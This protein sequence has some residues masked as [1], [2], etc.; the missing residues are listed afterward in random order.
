MGKS[1][2]PTAWV[3]VDWV[4]GRKMPVVYY[5]PIFLIEECIVRWWPLKDSGLRVTKV[6]FSDHGEPE[7]TEGEAYSDGSFAMRNKFKRRGVWKYTIT[8]EKN[9]K[10][11]C[12]DPEACN[13]DQV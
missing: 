13:E 7:F 11:F 9:G 12:L 2:L 10:E 6:A 5:D 3:P 8:V 1:N 4:E